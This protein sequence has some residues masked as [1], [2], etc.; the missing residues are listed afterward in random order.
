M[1]L[2]CATCYGTGEIVCEQGPMTCPH[3]FGDGTPA[4]KGTK[5]EWRLR[6]I[7]RGA[8]A[9]EPERQDDLLWL[10]HELRRHREALVSI[11][12]ICQDADDGDAL[13]RRIKF[14]AN[15]AVGLYEPMNLP[16]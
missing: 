1:N 8:T 4:G 11:L 13:A 3:C 2:Q 6:E 10:I 12:S 5:I 9:L 15:E 16:P 14:E 7:E